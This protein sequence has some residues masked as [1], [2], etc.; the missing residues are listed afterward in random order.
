MR[1][2]IL[3]RKALSRAES[4][5]LQLLA[6]FRV[7]T[8]LDFI[9]TFFPRFLSSH[10]DFNLYAIACFFLHSLTLSWSSIIIFLGLD[11]IQSFPT[12]VF[13]FFLDIQVEPLGLRSSSTTSHGPQST[14]IAVLP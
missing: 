12:K 11:Y 7:C 13:S 8:N 1:M 4:G 5:L 6:H 9:N 10:N 2:L 3:R 14:T